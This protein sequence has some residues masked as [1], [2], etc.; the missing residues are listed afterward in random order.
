M[1]NNEKNHDFS[2]GFTM[3]MG[4]NISKL[5]IMVIITTRVIHLIFDEKILLYQ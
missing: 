5:S 4:E 3:K 2:K 1:K